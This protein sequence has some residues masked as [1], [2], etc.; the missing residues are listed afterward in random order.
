MRAFNTDW[1]DEIVQETTKEEYQNALVRLRDDSLVYSDYDIDT[2]EWLVIGNGV[3]YT[4]NARIIGI[5]WGV[6]H[7][8]ESQSNASTEKAIRVQLP[9]QAV[10]RV[11]KGV[12]VF[13]DSCPRNP[14]LEGLIFT[15]TQDFQG[16][17]AGARTLECALDGDA[18]VTS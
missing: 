11:K 16:S 1:A 6:F 8:G 17:M 10:G 7:G 2:A 13:V 5:R 15:V 14:A 12:K 3:I 4:G 9:F 18:A